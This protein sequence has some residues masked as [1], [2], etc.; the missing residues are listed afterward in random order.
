MIITSGGSLQQNCRMDEVS[1]GNFPPTLL[2]YSKIHQVL[3]Y[4]GALV[5]T[6]SNF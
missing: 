4:K 5:N 1:F 2:S 3:V 6:P